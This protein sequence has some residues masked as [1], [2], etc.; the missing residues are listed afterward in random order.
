MFQ[1]I[2][3]RAKSLRAQTHN[4]NFKSASCQ[5]KKKY[6]TYKLAESEL[7]YLR[8]KTDTKDPMTPYHCTY[9]NAFHIGTVT[10]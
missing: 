2:L 6:A 5:G 4:Y 9:C 8:R 7:R 3:K 10:R 1:R